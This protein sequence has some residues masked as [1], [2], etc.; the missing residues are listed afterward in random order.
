MVHFWLDCY[1]LQVWMCYKGS[2]S[3]P[4]QENYY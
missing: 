1:H 4:I 3:W 2:W